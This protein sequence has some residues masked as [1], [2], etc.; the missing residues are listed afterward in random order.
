MIS[1]FIKTPAAIM[2]TQGD[3]ENTETLLKKKTRQIGL[4]ERDCMSVAGQGYLLLD[5][6]EELCGGIEIST[7]TVAENAYVKIRIRFGGICFRGE[8]YAVCQK[9]VQRSFVAGF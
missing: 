7:F 8:Q 3:F 9:L 2:K 1:T 5:Y 6:G 4:A